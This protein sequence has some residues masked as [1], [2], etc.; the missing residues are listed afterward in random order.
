MINPTTYENMSYDLEISGENV[1]NEVGA[2]LVISVEQLIKDPGNI[3]RVKFKYEK[4]IKKTAA[5]FSIDS[6]KWIE[7]DISKSYIAGIKSADS[8]IKAIGGTEKATN[9]IVMGASLIK[10]PPPIAP[11]PPIPGQILIDFEGYAAHTEFFGVFRAAAYYS[12]EDKPLQIMRKAD[13]IFRQV[14]VKVGEASFQEGN[15]VTRKILS[16]RLLDEY[17]KKGLQSVLYKNGRRVSIDS[18][19][20]MLGRTLTGRCALQASIN[21]YVERGYSLGIVSA[22]FRSCDLCAPFEGTILSMDGKD[23]RYPSI[24]DAETQGLFHPNCKHDISPFYEELAQMYHEVSQGT[25]SIPNDHPGIM[26][27]PVHSAEM[28]L[29]N[30]YGYRDAQIYAYKAQQRQRYIERQIRKWKRYKVTSLNEVSKKRASNKISYW[31]K[32]Q[33]EHLK[34]NTYLPRKYKREQIKKAF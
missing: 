5:K 24:W 2:A 17:A 28:D 8:E 31:Q 7:K 27:A 13:D 30:K 25:P 6:K 34:A 16:Q 12:L 9:G 1:V 29:I 21:R 3:S 18:Y 14:A 11:I 15:I 26:G 22:H 19:C 4:S 33:R 32:E 20:E 23:K 10:G